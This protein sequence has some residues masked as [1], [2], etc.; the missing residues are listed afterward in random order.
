MP[1]GRAESWAKGSKLR[2]ME[3]ADPRSVRS[4]QFEAETD[5]SL[6][7]LADSGRRARGS[8]WI[9]A[10][11]AIAAP[12]KQKRGVRKTQLRA[13][14]EACLIGV[15]RDSGQ[16]WGKKGEHKPRPLSPRTAN[17]TENRNRRNTVCNRN[18]SRFLLPERSPSAILVLHT[19]TCVQARSRPHSNTR[20]T[21]QDNV[22]LCFCLGRGARGCLHICE[23]STA[24]RGVP[25]YMHSAPCVELCAELC[26]AT[27]LCAPLPQTK[28]A[29]GPAATP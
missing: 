13:M 7:E 17:S 2:A 6:E 14:L 5:R 12:L 25:T 29:S 20:D 28:H 10:T 23:L 15:G 24:W 8:R 16:E 11:N 9:F 21:V 4:A 26:A 3:F 27:C 22:T 19:H 18:P 1:S